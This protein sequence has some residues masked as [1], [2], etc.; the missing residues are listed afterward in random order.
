MGFVIMRTSATALTVP[1][2]LQVLTLR[3]QKVILD[4]H[5]AKLYGGSVK[6]LNQ[7]VNRNR[8]RFPADFIFQ[9]TAEEHESLR[10]QTATS[11]TRRRW[12]PLYAIG[13]HRTW[14]DHGCDRAQLRTGRQNERICGARF[15][16]AKRDTGQ[17]SSTRGQDGRTGAASAKPRRHHPGNNR[18]HQDA[19]ASQAASAQENWM[20]DAAGK[21]AASPIQSGRLHLLH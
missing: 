10:V 16:T 11:N 7:Q 15:G 14:R 20:A 6:R 2:E 12:T 17:R 3:N 5:L 9:I 1:V 13:V 18:G 19:Y 21:A 4:T 8:R